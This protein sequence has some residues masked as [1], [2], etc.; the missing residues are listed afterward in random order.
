MITETINRAILDVLSQC[1]GY[2][3]KEKS[4]FN[5]VNIELD[6]MAVSTP[7]LKEHLQYCKGKDWI[8]YEHDDMSGQDKW[9]I[10]AR[11]KVARS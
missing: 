11:G 7:E 2:P 6:A 4:L 1:S 9:F 3:L 10:T 5:Q 8:D